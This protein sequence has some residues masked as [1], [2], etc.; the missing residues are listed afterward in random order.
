MLFQ[1]SHHRLE[2]D[3]TLHHATQHLSERLDELPN[4]DTVRALRAALGNDRG[5]VLHWWD[6]ER[7]VLKEVK[8]QLQALPEGVLTDRTELLTFLDDLLGTDATPG[9]LFDLG[10]LIRRTVFF[11]GTGGS[12]SL[13]KVL[14]AL[15]ATS[16][17]LREKYVAPIYG[18]AASIPSLN[19]ARQA[20]VQYDESGQIIDPY[21]L[22]GQ[23]TNDDDLTDLERLEGDGPVVADGGAAMVA[24]ALLQN[25][26]LAEAEIQDLR[27]Q[28]LRYCELDTFAMVLAWEGIQELVASANSD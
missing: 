28:L 16:P 17:G 12:S 7:T 9:R 21:S 15:L 8:G 26:Q 11:P 25:G 5:V 20:W 18:N 23:R 22:L 10:H 14:P 13:K 27:A 19:F 24:Y 2:A 6:H 3:G 1:F 4:F